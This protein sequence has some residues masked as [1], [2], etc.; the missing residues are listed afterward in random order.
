[1]GNLGRDEGPITVK[2]VGGRKMNGGVGERRITK[3]NTT[4][5]I[6]RIHL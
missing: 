3:D 5:E 1:M 2:L 6:T 4:T